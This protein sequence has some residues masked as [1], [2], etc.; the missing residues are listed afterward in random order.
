MPSRF[1]V[2]FTARAVGITSTT[3]SR[4]RSTSDVGGDRLDLGDDEMRAFLLDQPAQRGPV[5]HRDHVRAVRDLMARRVR[6]AVDGDH[7]DAETLQR[8]DHFLAELAAAQQHHLG[9]GGGKRRADGKGMRL[10]S[11]GH[12]RDLDWLLPF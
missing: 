6:V 9:R 10:A 4:S 3:P 2:S 1:I 7:F 5:G 8:D 12:G 11:V